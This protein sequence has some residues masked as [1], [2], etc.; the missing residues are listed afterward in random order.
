MSRT[1]VKRSIEAPVETVFDTIAHIE[2]FRKAIPHIEKVEFAS[3]VQK[4]IG[5]R[6]RETRN[7]NG[8]LATVE[9][10]V[11]DYVENERVRL[12]SDAGGTVWDSLFTTESSNGGTNLA[13]T[14]DAKPYRF[15]ARLMNPLVKGMIRKSIEKDMDAVK[16]Y[17]EQRDG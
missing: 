7:M 8:R 14:M 5:T 10:E 4:G 1:V 6:F 3:D 16:A 15:L 13:L 17:C 11:T 2:N 9:M 12:V